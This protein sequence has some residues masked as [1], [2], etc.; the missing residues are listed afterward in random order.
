MLFFFFFNNLPYEVRYV[1]TVCAFFFIY[2]MNLLCVNRV[3]VFFFS[4]LSNEVRY[5]DRVLVFLVF[6]SVYLMK[7]DNCINI[8]CGLCLIYQVK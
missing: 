7:L 3:V 5:V 6:F 2:V 8:A 1:D 4:N